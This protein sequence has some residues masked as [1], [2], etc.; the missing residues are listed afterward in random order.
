MILRIIIN[1]F[2]VIMQNP[3]LNNL[4]APLEEI[5]SLINL[6]QKVIEI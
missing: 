6:F 1:N 3:S 2:K 4:E 5:N